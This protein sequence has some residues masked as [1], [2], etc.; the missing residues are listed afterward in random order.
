MK[1]RKKHL[2]V[3]LFSKKSNTALDIFIKN[4]FLFL[5][6][7]NL[8]PDIYIQIYDFMPLLVLN[9]HKY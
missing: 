4:V 9:Q 2:D 1:P 7:L 5:F 3:T 8:I 6:N